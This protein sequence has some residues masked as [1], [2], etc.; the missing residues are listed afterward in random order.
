MPNEQIVIS[1]DD[2]ATSSVQ[3]I[4][5][6]LLPFEVILESTM[7]DNKQ[8]PYRSDL[9]ITFA[10]MHG[11]LARLPDRYWNCVTYRGTGTDVP[12]P[13]DGDYLFY[14]LSCARG[15]NI[16]DFDEHA[17]AVLQFQLSQYLRTKGKK[18]HAKRIMRQGAANDRGEL[19]F[20]NLVDM[21]S[22]CF[23]IFHR[24][25]GICKCMEESMDQYA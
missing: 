16:V 1:P 22:M 13:R 21:L 23:A 17:A 9:P 3:L 24:A 15:N 19:E 7:H 10:I 8:C 11:A 14:S 25:S 4:T 2:S 18:A 12:A 5:N 20:P 6:F